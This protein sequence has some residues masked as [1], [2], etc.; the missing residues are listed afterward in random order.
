MPCS[1]TDPGKLAITKRDLKLVHADRPMPD[2]TWI[3]EINAVE[4]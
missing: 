2:L 4:Y 3:V 1:A